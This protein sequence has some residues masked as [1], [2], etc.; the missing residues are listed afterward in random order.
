MTDTPSL[1]PPP[2]HRRGWS[3]PL[4]DFVTS[5]VEELQWAYLSTHG[6][7]GRAA[8]TASLARLRRASSS[9]P[10]ADPLVWGETL[11]GL[12]TQYHGTGN[13]P[14]FGENA[15][16]A[17]ITLF[18]IH[19]QSKQVP[20]H[21]HGI[22]LGRAVARL[23]TVN[24]PTSTT[25]PKDAAVVR[26]FLT[27]GTATSIQETLHHARGLIS[28]LRGAA[29]PLDYGLLAS[30][31]AQLQHPRFADGVRLDWGRDFYFPTASN[32]TDTAQPNTDAP[33]AE[34]ITL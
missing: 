25:T 12:P 11:D 29:I 15:A 18:A 10:G 14:T 2:S 20:M 4:A 8:A 27:L 33:A 1:T 7:P 34:S 22:S 9:A 3:A 26:R 24:A 31:F 23:A 30:H 32:K 28:Q 5:R 13:E 6:G 16:H 21:Q 19:Q 17:A